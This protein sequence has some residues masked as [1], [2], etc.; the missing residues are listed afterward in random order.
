MEKIDGTNYV[1]GKLY[2]LID[3]TCAAPAAC[4]YVEK[5]TPWRWILIG[6]IGNGNNH[7]LLGCFQVSGEGHMR[8]VKALTVQEYESSIAPSRFADSIHELTS[9]GKYPDYAIAI[10]GEGVGATTADVLEE[11]YGIKVQRIR[12]GRKPPLSLIAPRYLNQ[13][14]YANFAAKRAL[15][16]GRLQL[17]PDQI[18]LKQARHIRCGMNSEGELFIVPK[19]DMLMPVEHWDIYCF[20]QLV[21]IND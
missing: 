4:S 17:R 20:A 21:D 6:I 12:W 8:T 19:K 16:D 18:A 7:S 14:A 10:D 15:E 3:Q 5:D 1:P 9:S 2:D 13:R 11:K